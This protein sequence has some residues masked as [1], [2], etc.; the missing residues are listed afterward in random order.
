[1][2]RS[3]LDTVESLLSSR[4]QDDLQRHGQASAQLLMLH[5]IGKAMEGSLESVERTLQLIAEA[6][7]VILQVERSFLFLID[8]YTQE[9]VAKAGS[10]LVTQSFVEKLRI[11]AGQG[12]LGDVVTTGKPAHIPDARNDPRAM[13]E[14]IQQLGVRNLL[15][16]PL[17][18]GNRILGVILA[19]SR[20]SGEP[21]TDSDLQLLSVLG[22]LAAVTEENAALIARLKKKTGRLQALLEI[23]RALN[24]TREPR[25]LMDLILSKA[26][27][28]TGSSGGSVILYDSKM[29]RLD[30]LASHGLSQSTAESLKLE[31]GE[32]ITGWVAREKKP[33][34]INDVT[35]DDRYVQANPEVKS[36]LAVPMLD[37]GELIGVINMDAFTLNAFE[38][39]DEDLLCSFAGMATVA[40]RNAQ[41]FKKLSKGKTPAV[42]GESS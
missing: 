10:G 35:R 11:P 32:G 41:L 12:I 37:H 39:E 16:A 28:L 13:H 31:V 38:Q 25:E 8:P 29:N 34:L 4:K 9:L 42:N 40:L 27:E 5:E 18:M 26:L 33:L 36:E 21:F 19:D 20:L 2:L 17:R 14:L 3:I 6:V 15:V 23:S 1:M 7:T 22:S 24:A 30:I